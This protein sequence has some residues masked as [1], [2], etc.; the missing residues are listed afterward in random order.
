MSTAK[1]DEVARG[2]S[3]F[4][5]VGKGAEANGRKDIAPLLPAALPLGSR[6]SGRVHR[7]KHPRRSAADGPLVRGGLYV[8][9]CCHKGARTHGNR[10]FTCVFHVL[11]ES[12]RVV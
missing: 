9:R 6:P 12:S 11:L 1:N 4:N 3:D 2:R 10:I 5:K 7:G 8:L